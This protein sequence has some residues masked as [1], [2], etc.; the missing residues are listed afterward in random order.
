MIQNT[1]GG[2]KIEVLCIIVL[3]HCGKFISLISVLNLTGSF[4][5]C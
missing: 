4:K 1:V 2:G 5:M 3:M